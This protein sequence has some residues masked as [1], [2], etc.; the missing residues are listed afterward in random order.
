MNFNHVFYNPSRVMKK[1]ISFLSDQFGM[2]LFHMIQVRLCA[3]EFYMSFMQFSVEFYRF[4][5]CSAF[6]S[7][8]I[9]VVFDQEFLS[10]KNLRCFSQ[11]T[12]VRMNIF[13]MVFN[14]CF[15]RIFYFGNTI[16][17]YIF[18]FM[19]SSNMRYSFFCII[20][21]YPSLI[22]MIIFVPFQTF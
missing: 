12:L 9:I 13:D 3:I 18:V 7:M 17:T 15:F 2:I 16:R 19:L 14:Q 11:M 6:L 21:E 1:F 5:F 20:N 10:W 22:A 8:I 4:W